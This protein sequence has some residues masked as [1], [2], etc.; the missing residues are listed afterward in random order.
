MLDPVVR[1]VR[2]IALVL[3]ALFMTAVVFVNL[4]FIVQA[5]AMALVILLSSWYLHYGEE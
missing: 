1:I 5:A 2:V 3:L 4:E